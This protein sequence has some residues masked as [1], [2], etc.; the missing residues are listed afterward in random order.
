MSASRAYNKFRAAREI[1]VP[2]LIFLFLKYLASPL[3]EILYPPLPPTLRMGLISSFIG[4]CYDRKLLT[5]IM[6]EILSS[7]FVPSFMSLRFTI[8]RNQNVQML[9][10]FKE[11]WLKI[12]Y[13]AL[14]I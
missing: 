12:N 4:P 1:F 8:W 13:N 14:I 9:R 7:V 2:I 3:T 5:Y 10:F 6:G 11:A